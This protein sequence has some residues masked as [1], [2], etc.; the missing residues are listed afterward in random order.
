[1]TG[2]DQ[3]DVLQAL[4]DESVREVLARLDETPRSAKDLA[5][6][7]DLSLPTVYRRLDTLEE[8]DLVV[9]RT[10]PASDGNHYKVYECNFDS[11]VIKLADGAFEVD[12]Y[13]RESAAERFAGLWRE[14][15][16]R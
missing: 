3:A 8:L 7:M 1:M 12:V 11:T 5:D 13:R 15:S 9:S 10:E 2:S 14:L 16:D 4:A 6:T